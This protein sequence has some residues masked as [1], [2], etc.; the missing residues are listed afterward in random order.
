MT[1][2]SCSMLTRDKNLAYVIKAYAP[3]M[4]PAE[5]DELATRVEKLRYRHWISPAKLGQRLRVTHE[6]R[7][8]LKLWRIEACDVSE[9]ERVELRKAKDRA[10]SKARR[11]SSARIPTASRGRPTWRRRT[12]RTR[13]TSRSPGWPRASAAPNGIAA[14]SAGPK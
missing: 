6:V 2:G 13:S 10:R 1:C 5:R 14:K 11:A 3:W 12:S 7:E 4:P 8:R 9:E